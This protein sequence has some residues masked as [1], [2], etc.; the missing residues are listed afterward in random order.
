MNPK[1]GKLLAN[2]ILVALGIFGAVSGWRF[3]LWRGNIPGPGLLPFVVS[4]AL[5]GLTLL[6]T[7]ADLAQRGRPDEAEEEGE[8][9]WGKFFCYVGALAFAALALE[10]L[11]Y[12]LT[13]S[14]VFVFILR[15]AERL[16]WVKTVVVT[17][18]TLAVCEALF[19]R[20]LGV[21]L[22]KGVLEAL[23]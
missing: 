17:L 23:F 18:A 7:L 19:V 8:A 12:V 21:E 13:V 1:A 15:F 10:K 2:A 16:S 9:T 11:G 6:A 20:A 22:P 14:A 3:G 5:I 4:V